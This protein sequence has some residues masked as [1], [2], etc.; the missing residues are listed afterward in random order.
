M[1]WE[2]GLG[3]PEVGREGLEVEGWG[4]KWGSEGRKCGW[5]RKWGNKGGKWGGWGRKWVKKGRKWGGWGRKQGKKRPEVG[6]AGLEMEGE[7]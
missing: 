6:L 4:R 5:G 2:V 1:R 7:P 3:E